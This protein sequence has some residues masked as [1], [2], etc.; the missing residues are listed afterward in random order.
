[1]LCVVCNNSI[2]QGDEIQCFICKEFTHFIC[3]GLRE[4]KFRKL[5]KQAKDNW[6]CNTCKFSKEQDKNNLLSNTNKLLTSKGNEITDETLNG[7]IDSVQ[8]MSTQFDHFGQQL[9]SLVS[10]INE[11]KDENK[12]INEENI[13]LRKELLNLSQRVNIIEQ[14]SLECHAELIG[15]P[16]IQNEICTDTIDKITSTLGLE[17]KVKN[18][19]RIP[20]KS[21]DKPRKISV[22]FMSVEEKHKVMDLMK[23]KKMVAKHIDGKW[24]NTAIYVNEQMTSTFR[25]LFF[26]T[27][28]IAKEVGYKFIW[29]KNNKI[30]VKKNEGSMT[31]Y[32]V[33]EASISKIK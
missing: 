19:F 20:S 22:C 16:E 14:K 3:A 30:F 10:T 6:S 5:N 17:I 7:V 1:M 29:F 24:N 28:N 11:L 21:T 12:Q 32:I 13:F 33:D 26:K 15:V 23:K 9:K 31:I 8:F 25:N 2:H 4:G 18:A 27:R